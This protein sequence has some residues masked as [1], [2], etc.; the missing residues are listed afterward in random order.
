P[1]SRAAP[2]FFFRLKNISA[3]QR[4]MT[5][6]RFTGTRGPSR[7][8]LLLATAFLTSAGVAGAQGIGSLARLDL[9][10]PVES[11]VTTSGATTIVEAG[12]GDT[13]GTEDSFTYLYEQRT[14]NFDIRVRVMDVDADDPGGAQQSAK[15]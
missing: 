6:Q 13:Y 15:A 9:N 12:G 1:S 3:S 11:T 5:K 8:P 2:S 10:N 14:G 4:S 7:L